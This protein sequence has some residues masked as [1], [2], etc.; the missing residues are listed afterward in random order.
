MI[1]EIEKQTAKEIYQMVIDDDC[2]PI[3]S[4]YDG[5]N[6]RLYY[7]KAV[8][9]GMRWFLEDKTEGH[10]KRAQQLKNLDVSLDEAVVCIGVIAEYEITRD[11]TD[12]LTERFGDELEMHFFQNP[13]SPDWHWLTIH[14]KKADK[15]VAVEKVLQ[16]SGF[17][18]E[19]LVVFGDNLNDEKMFGMG[20][21]KAVAVS[22]STE[23][24]KTLAD[25]I[26]GSNED[27]SVV[28]YILADTGL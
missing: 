27:D 18:K 13:Y 25:E 8:N 10:Y 21:K 22:N 6:E 24:I 14:D 3:I 2:S 17:G 19:Q 26:I 16:M 28:K 15:S 9:E 20:A 23:Q 11:L 1:N 7:D 12:K 5:A 4:G